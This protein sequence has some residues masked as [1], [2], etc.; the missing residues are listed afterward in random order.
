MQ[1]LWGPCFV[2]HILVLLV[3]AGLDCNGGQGHLPFED[4]C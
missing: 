2:L 1:L 4:L 3:A